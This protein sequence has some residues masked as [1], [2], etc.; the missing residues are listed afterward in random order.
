MSNSKEILDVTS[1]QTYFFSHLSDLNRKSKCP[2]PEELIYYSSSVLENYGL[3]SNF[4]EFENGKVQTK[5]LG[6]KLL[7]A[8]LKDRIEQK[9][10]YK[11]VADTSLI[12]CGYFS[13]SVNKKLLDIQY[14]SNLGQMAYEQLNYLSPELFDIPKFFKAMSSSFDKVTTLISVIAKSNEIEP[15]NHLI[16]K[17]FDTKKCK[18]Q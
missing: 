1:L 12:L 7:E 10:I 11:D 16:L 4:F 14:Y 13:N 6:L 3:S 2:V 18:K 15:F 5:V 9:R 8:Q 17:E